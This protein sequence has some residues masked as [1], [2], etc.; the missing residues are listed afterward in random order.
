M[1]TSLNGLSLQGADVKRE[2][3]RLR[4]V[5]RA[6]ISQE[7]RQ[8]QSDHVAE[9]NV[10]QKGSTSYVLPP[11]EGS[12]A[13]PVSALHGFHHLWNDKSFWHSAENSTAMFCCAL[14]FFQRGRRRI[15]DCCIQKLPRIVLHRRSAN[16]IPRPSAAP[17]LVKGLLGD[18]HFV[19]EFAL[20]VAMPRF[21]LVLCL[22]DPVKEVT[23]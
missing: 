21:S 2:V 18:L 9:S 14:Q 15:S 19:T 8:Q 23:K 3:A 4:H 17:A 16:I 22:L 20:V 13:G 6:R 1:Q 12:R 5:C 11:I 7:S 10:Q